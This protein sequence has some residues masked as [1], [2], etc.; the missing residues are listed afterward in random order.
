MPRNRRRIAAFGAALL[1]LF[2]GIATWA[3]ARGQGDRPRLGLF[4]TLPILW[5]ET[6]SIGEALDGEGPDHWARSALAADFQLMPLDTLDP[7]SLRSLDNL[8]MAQPRALAPAENVALDDWVRGGGHLLLFADPFLTEHSRFAIGDRR[9][10]QDIVLLS[11]ILRRWD[12]EL[13]FDE[14]QSAAE[15]AV[16]IGA[17]SLP[18]HLAGALRPVAGGT[19]RCAFE[20]NDAVA[21]CA[22]GKGRIVVVADAALLDKARVDRPG[23]AALKHLNRIAFGADAG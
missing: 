23:E 9:R 4:T 5:H 3:V 6:A 13:T 12:L 16:A 8:L 1:L 21:V 17:A 22:I 20:A 10:P 15:R 11:P 18:L 2:A 7:A 19:A 14:G